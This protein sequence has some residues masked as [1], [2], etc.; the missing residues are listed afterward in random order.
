MG[1]LTQ[2][3]FVAAC[4]RERRDARLSNRLF[5][6]ASGAATTVIAH[7]RC[8]AAARQTGNGGSV[9][10]EG[11]RIDISDPAFNVAAV[12]SNVFGDASRDSASSLL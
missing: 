8:A 5:K 11:R 7:A 4:R 6:T 1:A 9:I 3:L 10:R 2:P 12:A